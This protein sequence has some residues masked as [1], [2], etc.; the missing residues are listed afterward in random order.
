[1]TVRM[2]AVKPATTAIAT[3]KEDTSIT[4]R[5]GQGF[6]ADGGVLVV[7]AFH[8]VLRTD[9]GRTGFQIVGFCGLE[10]FFCVATVRES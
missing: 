3:D 8:A 1:M 9:P 5:V 2:T 7:I 4:I 6:H 10:Y